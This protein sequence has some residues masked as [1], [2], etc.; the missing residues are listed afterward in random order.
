[1]KIEL[2]N[3]FRIA[4]FELVSSWNPVDGS[5]AGSARSRVVIGSLRLR[6]IRA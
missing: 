1:M 3:S 6:S 5:S 4:S 2:S